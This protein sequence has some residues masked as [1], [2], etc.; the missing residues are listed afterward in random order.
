MHSILLN[1]RNGQSIFQN[2]PLHC[3]EETNELGN[4]F[5]NY[6]EKIEVGLRTYI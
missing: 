4:M 3:M 6:I 2:A 5:S 1:G